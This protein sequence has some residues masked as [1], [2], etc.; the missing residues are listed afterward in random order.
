MP[1]SEEPAEEEFFTAPAP[2]ADLPPEDVSEGVKLLVTQMAVGGSPRREIER[3]L[4]DE[5]GIA[6][7]AR[8]LAELFGPQG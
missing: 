8:V 7:P 1:V 6:D 3:R 4:E 5:F 2:H